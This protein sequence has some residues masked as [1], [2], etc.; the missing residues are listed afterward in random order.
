MSGAGALVALDPSTGESVRS[1]AA[2]VPDSR[3]GARCSLAG[4]GLSLEALRLSRSA[5]RREQSAFT[6]HSW[7]D[8]PLTLKVGTTDW[9]HA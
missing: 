2:A 6:P 4:G 5:Q 9:S 8:T 3:V 7:I 1:S